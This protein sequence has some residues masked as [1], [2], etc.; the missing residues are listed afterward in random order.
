[1]NKNLK[2]KYIS[3]WEGCEDV[4]SIAKLNTE[5]GLIHSIGTKEVSEDYEICTG[6][7][8]E[9]EDG[10]IEQVDTDGNYVIISKSDNEYHSFTIHGTKY[11]VS[12]ELEKKDIHNILGIALQSVI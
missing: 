6:E 8:I 5:T 2:V 7:F 4:V 1:M 3:C 9:Y 11:I 12:T 10:T